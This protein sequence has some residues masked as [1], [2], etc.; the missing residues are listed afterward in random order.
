MG[1]LRVVVRGPCGQPAGGDLL[2]AA[3]VQLQS[4]RERRQLELAVGREST[5]QWRDRTRTGKLCR[6]LQLIAYLLLQLSQQGDGVREHH[7]LGPARLQA[8]AAASGLSVARLL[9]WHQ[10]AQLRDITTSIEREE[11]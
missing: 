3:D 11:H 2:G 7:V 10:L 9:R 1:P 4:T 8:L 5:K 6:A